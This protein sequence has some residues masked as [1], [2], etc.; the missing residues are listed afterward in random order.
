MRRRRLG[1]VE[2][3]TE[4]VWGTVKRQLAWRQESVWARCGLIV[5]WGLVVVVLLGSVVVGLG[6]VVVLLTD[7]RSLGGS[8]MLIIVVGS[9]AWAGTGG[10][11]GS[12]ITL[13]AW[14]VPSFIIGA[15]VEL[16]GCVILIDIVA[17]RL[18]RL[19]LWLN[20]LWNWLW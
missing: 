9:W 7:G 17:L 19:I 12:A 15:I 14:V 6:N 4:T 18:S 8:G 20:R 13:E 2:S 1:L 11:G 3:I 5:V 16:V 10:R